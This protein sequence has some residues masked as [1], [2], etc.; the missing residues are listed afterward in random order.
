MQWSSAAVRQLS[1]Y[2]EL[3]WSRLPV[4]M[5][6]THLSLSHIPTLK[7]KPSGYT[8]EVSDVRASLGAGFTYPIAGAL[9]T[10]PGLPGTPR[11]LDVDEKGNILGL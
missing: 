1:T 11:G 4:C 2:R 10:M 6:K 5:A 9:V 8:F 7:G 3:G